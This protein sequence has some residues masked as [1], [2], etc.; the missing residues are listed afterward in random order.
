MARA[1]VLHEPSN[2]IN[3]A[4]GFSTPRSAGEPPVETR[5]TS[6]DEEGHGCRLADLKLPV[7]SVF[8]GLLSNGVAADPSPAVP[9]A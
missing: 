5:Y 9:V 8:T 2:V 1:S 6:L 3:V 4:S 7:S